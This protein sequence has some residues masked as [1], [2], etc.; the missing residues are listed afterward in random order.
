MYPLFASSCV[1]ATSR[2]AR[3]LKI[4]SDGAHVAA[5]ISLDE[6][7]SVAVELAG[8]SAVQV[9]GRG[10]PKPWGI[11]ANGD[12]PLLLLA[13][14]NCLVYGESPA[15]YSSGSAAAELMNEW[16]YSF[17]IRSPQWGRHGTRNHSAIF[18]IRRSAGNAMVVTVPSQSAAVTPDT[19]RRLLDAAE[20]GATL[21]GHV[22]AL[23]HTRFAHWRLTSRGRP[24]ASYFGLPGRRCIR[25]RR[26]HRSVG[27]T[28]RNAQG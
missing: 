21:D 18:C 5:C 11:A 27:P 26:R 24:V 28:G 8:V 6:G 22:P 7:E 17:A 19:C 10:L 20:N 12:R 9:D 16:P 3:P 13:P 23:Q 25:E 15:G 4:R 2:A 14:G 1:S